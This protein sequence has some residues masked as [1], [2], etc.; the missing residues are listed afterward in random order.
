[1]QKASGLDL[2]VVD[3]DDALI[4]LFEVNR[5]YLYR[6]V[7]KVAWY[8]LSSNHHYVISDLPRTLSPQTSSPPAGRISTVQRSY[9]SEVRSPEAILRAVGRDAV[10]P[11]PRPWMV[12]TVGTA[13]DSA[14]F[15]WA[16]DGMKTARG[17]IALLLL[18]QQRPHR[19]WISATGDCR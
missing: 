10:D 4:Q 5:F 3:I 8:M 16:L 11:A 6:S 1:V 19:Q 7:F 12:D 15:P 14:V 9:N 18:R 2:R 13:V 17:V